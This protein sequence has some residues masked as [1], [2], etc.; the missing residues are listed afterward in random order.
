MDLSTP[1]T[2][3]LTLMEWAAIKASLET[4]IEF[5][6]DDETSAYP[7]LAT[8]TLEKV[9]AQTMFAIELGVEP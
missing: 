9:A 6:G 8:T 1:V 3:E 4:V 5:G 7:G 2:V